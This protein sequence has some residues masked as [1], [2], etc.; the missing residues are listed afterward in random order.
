M[1]KGKKFTAAVAATAVASAMVAPV[2]SAS[3]QLTDIP[4]NY[5]KDAILELVQKGIINGFE[6]NTFRPTGN[7][8]RQDFAIIMAKALEL[9][10]TNAPATATFSDVPTG[11]YSFAAVEAAVKAG[12]LSGEGNGKF[13]LNSNLTR[14]AMA[15]IFV[16]ALGVDVAG[17]GA[18]LKFADAG[19]ISTWAK[20]AVAF[21]VEAKLLSGDNNNNFNPQ[22]N[23]ER[24]QV[25]VVASNF[26]K[27]QDEYA[28]GQLKGA[29]LKDNE[30]IELSFTKALE[31]LTSAD[32]AVKVKATGASVGVQS[33]TLSAD[34]K[35]AT[36]KVAKLAA[37]TTFTVTYNGK[38][39][40]ISTEA[41]TAV[42]VTGVTAPSLKQIKVDFSGAIDDATDANFTIT[43]PGGSLDVKDISSVVVADDSKSVLIVLD[44]EAKNQDVYTV[45]VADIKAANGEA[46][47]AAE[48]NVTM[49]DTAIPTVA[50]VEVAGPHELKVKFSAPIKSAG[51]FSLDGG[52]YSVVAGAPNDEDNS[53]VLTVA[54]NLTEGEHTL[55]VSGDQVGYNEL[56]VAA[57]EHKFNFVKDTTAPTVEVSKVTL[58]D[59]AGTLKTKAT[60]KFSEKV[61]VPA[62]A[63]IYAVYNKV[64]QYEGTITPVSDT[65]LDVVFDVVLPTGVNTFFINNPAAAA[66][67]VIADAWGNAFAVGSFNGTLNL[68]TV[69]PTVTKV[70]ANGQNELFVHY[71]ET[72]IGADNGLNYTIKDKDGKIVS[73]NGIDGA[74][75][76]TNA[77][78]FDAA[79][80]AYKISIPGGLAEGDYSVTIEKVKDVA[81]P[82]ANV[83]DPVTVNFAV[84]DST[85]P[86]VNDSIKVVTSADGKVSKIFVTYS[87][88]MNTVGAGSITA[89]SAYRYTA[90]GTVHELPKNSTVTAA[91]NNMTAVITLGSSITLADITSFTVGAVSDSKGLYTKD[92]QTVIPAVAILK[93][94]IY[95]DDIV[96]V[97]AVG[98]KKITFEVLQP[99]SKIDT[100][101]FKI[102]GAVVSR[103]Y[104][105][106]KLVN[107][108]KTNGALVT[109]ELQDG[110]ALTTDL[111]NA[112]DIVI[113]GT[114]LN[115]NGA[116][117]QGVGNTITID[118][119]DIEDKIAATIMSRVTTEIDA[120]D[121]KIDAIDVTFSEDIL[122]S[123]VGLDSFTVAGYTVTDV[124]YTSDKTVRIHVANKSFEDKANTPVVTLVKK[125]LD[126]NGNETAPETTG[127][128]AT[129]GIL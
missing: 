21:A 106:L 51:T 14:E 41:S 30:T 109:L 35:S 49:F 34:K 43:G 101:T 31:S 108:G 79:K 38:T 66:D 60:F 46:V 98:K 20:D 82:V 16:N 125:V 89:T 33:V 10:L 32:V 87:K 102:N 127:V 123:S 95:S 29:T 52:T 17:K 37:S 124:T 105:E 50:G 94:G 61:T 120:P 121:G 81:A 62:T 18:D 56:K 93:D 116:G 91:D 24:Q 119:A 23:A 3:V 13:G 113:S 8:K 4:N 80:G 84:V 12:L 114:L 64:P 48:L 97:K 70:T 103:A 65:Q 53:V 2:A 85:N 92:L 76:P 69:K 28:V 117:I 11:H 67:G 44:E 73:V 54:A 110:Q 118:A 68:D 72:V 107:G 45:A 6:D 83:I 100:N 129:V 57:G 59:D 55:K 86:E 88:P 78:V 90:G 36:V 19:S 128:A 39:A 40:E 58:V 47:N 15:V 74:G 111:S 1:N 22:A 63:T 112:D 104:Y 122:K 5:A 115:A 126:K 42:E 75:H 77:P 99:L 96:N 27:V 9:D 26:L 25:A 71:S 7:I